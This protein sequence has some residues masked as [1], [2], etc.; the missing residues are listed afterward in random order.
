MDSSGR[1]LR[2][3]G[4]IGTA[5]QAHSDTVAGNSGSRAADAESAAGLGRHRMPSTADAR[6][7][8][9]LDQ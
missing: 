3:L 2:L 4:G 9:G 1:G 7:S 5:A 6:Q 8:G